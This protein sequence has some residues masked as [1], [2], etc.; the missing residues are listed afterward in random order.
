[1]TKFLRLTAA[2]ATVAV[3]LGATSASAATSVSATQNANAHAKIMKPLQI[4]GTQDLDFGT[5]V[6]SGTGTQTMSVSQAG[7][8]TGCGAVITCSG[9]PQAAVYNVKGTPNA[10]VKVTVAS[11]VTLTNANDGTTLDLTPSAPATV[12]LDTNAASTGDNFNIGG[13]ISIDSAATTDGLYSGT[14]AVSVDYQ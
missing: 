4:K 9:T 1:M 11:P 13:S 6:I 3:A 7:A 14:F 5:M 2:A 8:L 10:T 12:L